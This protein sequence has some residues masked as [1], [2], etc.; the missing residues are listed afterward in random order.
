MA[1]TRAAIL[2]QA[3]SSGA[4]LPD[5]PMWQAKGVFVNHEPSL[6]QQC[7]YSAKARTAHCI[8]PRSLSGSH[9]T[10]EENPGDL[11][12][13]NAFK[14]R[15]SKCCEES[16]ARSRQARPPCLRITFADEARFGPIN[17]ANAMLG[18]DRN[19]ARSRLPAH[20]RLHLFV[21]RG[22]S[23][24]RHLR[25]SDHADIEYRMLPGFPQRPRAKV[26]QAGYPLGFRRRTQ[27]PL[28]RPCASPQYLA[29]L[30]ALLTRTQP[31]GRSVG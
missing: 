2:L 15:L 13:Q 31:E 12:A 6:V 24:G 4:D 21:R 9:L 26:R 16:K 7:R 23:E 20:S 30:A 28:W 22:L 17:L 5:R 29:A 3:A 25:L 11:A 8:D 1:S 10:S 18:L 14:K 27:P 19:Q